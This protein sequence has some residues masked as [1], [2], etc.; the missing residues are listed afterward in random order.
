MWQIYLFE[1]PNSTI[2][3]QPPPILRTPQTLSQMV[4]NK[5]Y[6][7]ETK[8]PPCNGDKAQKYILET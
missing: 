3:P 2:N 7:M 6:N 5:L 4:Q 8:E 1:K